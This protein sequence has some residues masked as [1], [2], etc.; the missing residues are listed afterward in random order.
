MTT[1]YP[2]TGTGDS[3][4][5]RRVRKLLA[6]AQATD[7]P[8]EAEAF[9][10][11]AA[12]LVQ[13]LRIDP[14]RLARDDDRGLAVRDVHLGR[15]A[16]VRAR[17]ALLAVIAEANDARVVFSATPSGTVAHV[18]GF[19]DDLDA[20]EV[21]YQ[22][23]HAQAAAQMAGER[24]GTAAATQ[25]FRRSFLFGFADRIGLLLDESHRAADATSATA[26]SREIA[27]RRRADTVEEFAA[28]TFGRVRAARRAGPATVSGFQAGER[29]A[30]RADIGRERLAA[31]PQ[32]GSG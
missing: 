20:I 2:S 17:L 19:V 3:A 27:L 23:L 10:R 16:Y 21:L 5:L 26:A 14:D 30:T 31:R 12:E 6:K 28:A 15:G 8:H 7:N 1:S 9:S 25:R 4:G 32:L 29:A 18:A 24:R 11:K 13:E 22:G